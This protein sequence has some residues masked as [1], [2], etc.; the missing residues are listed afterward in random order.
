MRSNSSPDKLDRKTI[1]RNRRIHMKSLCFKLTSLVPP[2]HFKP[3]KDMLS[4]QDQLDQVATYIKQLRDRVQELEGRKIKLSLGTSGSK[5][6]TK[7][8]I[9]T[10]SRLP[11]VELRESGS[12]LEVVLVSG[13][14]KNYLLYEVISILED[15]GAEVL[16]AT[17]STVG[18]KVFHTV[19]AQVRISRF[20]VETARACQR[21]QELV[22]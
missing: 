16:S 22:C 20:G 5:N 14:E 11:V 21:L 6:N 8:S 2:H 17:M 15:E 18:D 13:L 4:Q 10:G 3:S 12:T 9:M 1:E 19:H 7:D